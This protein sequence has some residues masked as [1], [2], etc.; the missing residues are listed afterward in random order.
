MVRPQ[1]LLD[2]SSPTS[3]PEWATELTGEDTG[4]LITL[5]DL[6]LLLLCFFVIWHVVDKQR[7]PTDKH[8]AARHETFASAAVSQET[9]P[10]LVA[11][12]LLEPE[13]AQTAQCVSASLSLQE[14][15]LLPHS[16]LSAL[17]AVPLLPPTTLEA[18]NIVLSASPWDKLQEEMEQYVRETGLDQGVGVVSTQHE[19]LISL[20][21]R[22]PFASGSAD[23]R[24]EVLPIL[25]KVAAFVQRSSEL[26]VEIL[27]HTDDI[28]ISTP[29]FPSN[30]EL[31]A[32]RA[33]RV[34][35]Y[36]I[37]Q[38][39]APTRISTQGYAS[40]R[41]LVPN[42]SADNRAVNRRV[43]VR[44]YRAVDRTTHPLRSEETNR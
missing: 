4:W 14:A 20:H 43:E 35:R 26:A 30:W 38:G 9:Q 41:P 16:T 19:L 31:S 39:I 44:L 5:S 23:L 6:T 33:S 24:Q 42:T 17:S 32:A 22:V 1:P 11:P 18:A 3:A 8:A 27:G 2:L 7:A 12:F 13:T 29:A 15:P 36:L 21:D 37:E 34:A 25:K 28:P 10:H 40:F